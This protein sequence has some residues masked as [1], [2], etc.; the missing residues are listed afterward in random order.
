[1]SVT[2]IH[3][4]ESPTRADGVV[5]PFRSDVCRRDLQAACAERMVFPLA[6]AVPP[7]KFRPTQKSMPFRVI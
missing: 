7:N 6:L 2:E 5:E 4:M 1:M 3:T